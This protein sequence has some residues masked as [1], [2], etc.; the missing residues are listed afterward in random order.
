MFL[1]IFEDYNW[2]LTDC[3]KMHTIL[4]ILDVVS[5]L[6]KVTKKWIKILAENTTVSL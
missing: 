5:L 4:R 1:E 6:L 2:L 3:S